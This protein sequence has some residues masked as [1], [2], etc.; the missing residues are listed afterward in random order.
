MN[1]NRGKVAEEFMR[2]S[3]LHSIKIFQDQRYNDDV[4]YCMQTI[5][6][7][8]NERCTIVMTV[9]S[10]L[11]TSLLV[12]YLIYMKSLVFSVGKTDRWWNGDDRTIPKA[13]DCT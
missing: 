7:L 4:N 8:S 3:F 13:E 9:A 2:L 6:I 12:S 5:T 10:T 1:K 11:V